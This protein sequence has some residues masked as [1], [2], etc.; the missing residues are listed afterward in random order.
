MSRPEW[1]G[2]PARSRRRHASYIF[3]FW[4]ERTESAD[5]MNFVYAASETM[6]D[7]AELL[8]CAHGLSAQDAL[9]VA[10]CLVKADLRGV[11]THG[12]ARLPV[13]LGRLRRGLISAR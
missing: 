3:I 5:I 1:T 9:T 10:R 6:R 12:G 11:D 8:L 4:N 2:T 13:Y 7:F